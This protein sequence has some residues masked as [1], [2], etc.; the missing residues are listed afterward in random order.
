[1]KS[2]KYAA[3]RPRPSFT[4]VSIIS[5]ATAADDRRWRN[6]SARTRRTGD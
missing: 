6:R 3:A 4:S 5:P 1:M 2:L